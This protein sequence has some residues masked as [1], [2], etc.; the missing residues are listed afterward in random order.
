MSILVIL[1][2]LGTCSGYDFFLLT[3]TS[4]ISFMQA[5]LCYFYS[6]VSLPKSKRSSFAFFF[7]DR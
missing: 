6:A 3:Y 2:Y 7:R 5:F 4:S 1:R